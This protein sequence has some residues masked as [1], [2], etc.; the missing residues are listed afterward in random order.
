MFTEATLLEAR[1][2][3][4]QRLIELRGLEQLL[5][6]R[7]DYWMFAAATS[8][9]YLV[10][11]Q[12]LERKI[13]ALGRDYANWSEGVTRSTMQAVIS[14]AQS[15]TLGEKIEW[16]GRQRDPR[17]RFTNQRLIEMLEISSEEQRHL[18][19]IIS[20]ETKRERDRQRKERQRRSQ[21]AQPR[22]EYVASARERRQHNRREAKKLREEGKSLREIG[23]EL[24]V[25]HTQVRRLLQPRERVQ[26]RERAD[27]GT[28]PSACMVGGDY[29][30]PFFL[31]QEEEA[32]DRYLRRTK[33]VTSARSKT[34]VSFR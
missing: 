12:F 25:S 11:S 29:L 18:K 7:R 4:L 34:L 16:Q 14:R 26:P 5:P 3:D 20:E 2:D 8:L 9:S 28:C 1:L 24:G 10:E 30:N 22:D 31:P 32:E 27:D 17:Y 15:A 21:G 19:T 13:I 23:R 33:I 6:G